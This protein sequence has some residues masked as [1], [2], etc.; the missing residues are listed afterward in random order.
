MHFT[1]R[2]QVA[3]NMSGPKLGHRE[4]ECRTALL[5]KRRKTFIG[6]SIKKLTK[7]LDCL[8]VDE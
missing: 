6:K 7:R 5:S 8:E 2:H 1:D 4:I 3:R